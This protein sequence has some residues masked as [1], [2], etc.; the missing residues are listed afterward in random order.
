MVAGIIILM[1]ESHIEEVPGLKLR[2]FLEYETKVSEFFKSDTQ[3]KTN[4]EKFFS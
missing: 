1:P 2:N 3:N 4:S